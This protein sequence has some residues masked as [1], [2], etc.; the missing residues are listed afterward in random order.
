MIPVRRRG[1]AVALHV[2]LVLGSLATL[3]PF[4]FTLATSL[5][6]HRDIAAGNWVFT[7][8]V[9]NYTRLFG[10]DSDFPTLAGN[11]VVVAAV[12]TLVVVAVGGLAAHSLARFRWPAWLVRG[13]LGWLLVVHLIPPV[14]FL[15]PLY[16]I[17][18]SLG[19]YD[20]TWGVVV[21]HVV[22]LLPLTVFILLDAFRSVPT[23]ITEAAT[24]DGA[25]NVTTFLRVV[26]PLT[27][28]GIAAAGII[29][30]IFSWR[31][32]AFALAVTSTTSGMTMPVGIASFVQE[33]AVIYG[34]MAAASM[35]AL[36]PALIAILFAQRRIV[37]GLTVGATAN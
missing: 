9:T 36:I 29:T 6:L 1:E 8:T 34:Q 35:L 26:L 25:G 15:F 21:G 30:F 5:K 3:L 10:S 11:S 24:V 23:A 7:P 12:T 22:F 4:V 32:Y 20:T 33:N 37:G 2:F 17:I 27:W 16:S 31:E 28:P 19:L 18:R 13:L 14:T